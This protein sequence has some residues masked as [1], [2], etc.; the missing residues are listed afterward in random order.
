M[1]S[2]ARP[3]AVSVAVVVLF[4][5]APATVL[6]GGAHAGVFARAG[7]GAHG[8]VSQGHAHRSFVPGTSVSPHHHRF[9]GHRVP[10]GVFA[11][12]VVIAPPLYYR[13][14]FYD[15]PAQIDPPATYSPPMTYASPPAYPPPP[16]EPTLSVAPAPMQ[17]VVEYPHG[18][19]ELRGDGITVPYTWVWIPN[20]PPPPPMPSPPGPSATAPAAPASPDSS[21][22]RHVTLYRWTDE[23]GVVHWTDNAESVPPRYRAQARQRPPS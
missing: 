4:T 5:C 9:F 15:S 6:A 11:A 22:S 19:Y 18:R 16:P 3:V 14:P 1:S 20:P 21:T 8:F 10:F 2:S 17:R 13:T 12:P 7:T 23:E